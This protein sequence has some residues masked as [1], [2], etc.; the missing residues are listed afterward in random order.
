LPRFSLSPR[1][2]GHAGGH[3]FGRVVTITIKQL[4]KLTSFVC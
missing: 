2:G 1:A 3:V 4:Y